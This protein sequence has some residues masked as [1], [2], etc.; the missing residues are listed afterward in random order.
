MY[1]LGSLTSVSSRPSVP[2]NIQNMVLSSLLVLLE[3]VG[4]F[5][6]HKQIINRKIKRLKRTKERKERAR[7][8]KRAKE[9]EEGNDPIEPTRK[10]PLD[11]QM[12]DIS[13]NRTE[14]SLTTDVASTSLPKPP[15]LSHLTCGINEVTKRLE[16]QARSRRY[17]QLVSVSGPS[18][19]TTISSS[20]LIEIPLSCVFVCRSDIDPPLLVAHLPELVASCN[21]PIPSRPLTPVHLISLPKQAESA[22]AESLALKRVSILAFDV[23]S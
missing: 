17:Q 9:G 19:P 5:N 21:V 3:G 1:C 7:A 13:N 23:R 18:G 20:E 16:K 6:L 14:D 15:I 22:L 4:E 10:E 11:Q 8:K 12:L 2:L